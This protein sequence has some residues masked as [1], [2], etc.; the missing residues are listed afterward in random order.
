MNRGISLKGWGESH[1]A[2]ETF[3]ELVITSFP[4]GMSPR[5]VMP[6][7]VS[8]HDGPTAAR[9]PLSMWEPGA[10]LVRDGRRDGPDA[11]SG[12]GISGGSVHALRHSIA[13]HPPKPAAASSGR[14][15]D[16][17]QFTHL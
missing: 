14:R 2:S 17:I 13:V 7:G 12:P 10:P 5:R 8:E 1:E 11:R 15:I 16:G 9:R 4:F 3:R 6:L